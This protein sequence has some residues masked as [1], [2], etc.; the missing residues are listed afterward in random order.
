MSPSCGMSAILYFSSPLCRTAPSEH[1]T[2]DC[3]SSPRGTLLRLV[4]RVAMPT[5]HTPVQGVGREERKI[6]LYNG[7]VNRFSPMSPIEPTYS[8]LYHL[9][10]Q[11]ILICITHQTNPFSSISPIKTTFFHPFHHRINPFLHI[12]HQANPFSPS[13]PIKT[14]YFHSF[15]YETNP[16][17]P[18]LLIK[19]IPFHPYHHQINPFLPISPKKQA[20]FHSYPPFNLTHSYLYQPSPQP[21]LTHHP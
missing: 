11:S 2:H 7:H 9:L 19:P 21:I 17:S 18:I 10:N 8:H 15:Y 3:A 1:N 20:H 5:P 14:T 16:F 6:E 13:S 4:L 12:P